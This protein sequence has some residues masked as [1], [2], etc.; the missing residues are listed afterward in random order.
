VEK[1][2]KINRINYFYQVQISSFFRYKY[3]P[4][5]IR[6]E[7][8]PFKRNLQSCRTHHPKIKNNLINLLKANKERFGLKKTW[9]HVKA[10]LSQREKSIASRGLLFEALEPRVLLAADLAYADATDLTLFYD[11]ASSEFQLIDNANNDNVISSGT[12]D[13]GIVA[14]SGNASNI[15]LNLDL[16]SFYDFGMPLDI[17]LEDKDDS[18][19][20]LFVQADSN[21][22]V[23]ALNLAVT[24]FNFNLSG[25]ENL[26]LSGGDSDN[27]FNL[28]DWNGSLT[29]DGGLGD[30]TL[31][32][33]GLA[34][35]TVAWELNGT[36]AGT[37][38]DVIFSGF[39]NLV[40][41]S[42]DDHFMFSSDG[43]ISGLIDGVGGSDTLDYS[44][45]NSKVVVDLGAGAAT[46]VSSFTNIDSFIG[47]NYQDYDT[48]SVVAEVQA[49]RRIQRTDGTI[50]TYL[51]ATP[52]VPASDAT[53]IDWV[54][55]YFGDESTY[56]AEDI[57]DIVNHGDWVRQA[58][59]S[60]YRY[61]GNA[62]IT[63]QANEPTDYT[64]PALDFTNPLFWELGETNWQL[65]DANTLVGLNQVLLDWTGLST[66]LTVGVLMASILRVSRI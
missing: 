2:V 19:D 33:P 64:N 52:L 40:G 43:S 21:F 36:N 45:Y 54:T 5:F 41:D 53:A 15:N 8:L 58:D 50:Y 47:G 37:V 28:V 22:T 30:D 42:G 66:R 57:P 38:G 4:F 12:A 29:V 14:I 61:T 18:N 9:L 10:A 65:N 62:S 51:G 1:H 16:A 55:Q 35:D 11:A 20:S 26:N 63:P 46:N 7:Y 59:G 44:D 32:E 48:S 3:P 49:G 24:D 17:Q 56:L 60:L 31:T 25:F 23:N 39:E 27:T 13:D 34:G 6:Y